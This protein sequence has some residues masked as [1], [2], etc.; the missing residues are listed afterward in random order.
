[1]ARQNTITV[2]EN[3]INVNYLQVLLNTL[4]H[5]LADADESGFIGLLAHCIEQNVQ[6]DHLCI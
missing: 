3:E 6:T 1:M 2:L 4:I 5:T